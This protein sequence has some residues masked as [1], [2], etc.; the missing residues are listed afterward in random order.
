M[1][2]AYMSQ[3]LNHSDLDCQRLSLLQKLGLELQ[4]FYDVGASD[5]CWSNRM[6]G[7]FPK[8]EF[9]LFEPLVDHVPAYREGMERCTTRHPR[10]HLHK[11]AV[12]SCCRRVS[13]T[14][15]PEAV[16][17][18]A[19]KMRRRPGNCRPVEVDMVSLDHAA[20]AWDLPAPQ[21]IKAD[22]QGSELAMLRG[23]A[24][25]LPQVEVLLLEC[26]LV[27][28]YGP[29]TPLLLEV[30]E[31]LG[32]RGFYLWDFGDPWRDA[33]GVLGAQDC[34]FLNARSKASQLKK[35]LRL[36]G[37]LARNLRRYLGR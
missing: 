4:C 8:A 20:R 3:T 25:M 16:G 17:S 12:G 19:L 2:S 28:S 27:R 14:V 10:F 35:E 13:M 32:R 29:E 37:R 24:R 23:A 18:T 33:E 11:V 15:Y 5:G 1:Q 7:A 31:W 34:V 9:Y 26:W 22:T 36:R 21:V 6:S 30:A